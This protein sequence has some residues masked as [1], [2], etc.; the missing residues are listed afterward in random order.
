MPMRFT[1]GQPNLINNNLMRETSFGTNSIC[2]SPLRELSQNNIQ[3][4]KH[5]KK[6]S[7]IM[8]EIKKSKYEKFINN[9]R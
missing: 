2:V 6:S 7:K 4:K 1:G 3:E 9:F 5:Q 8:S